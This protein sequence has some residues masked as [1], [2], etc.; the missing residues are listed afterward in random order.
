MVGLSS[1]EIRVSW[2]P[3]QPWLINGINQGY[4]V[5]LWHHPPSVAGI[6]FPADENLESIGAEENF[7]QGGEYYLR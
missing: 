7:D 3:P 6:D 1:S 5:Q 2:K 4:K